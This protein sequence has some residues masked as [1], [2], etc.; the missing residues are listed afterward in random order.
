MPG[1]RQRESRVEHRL[2]RIARS[3]R[4][5]TPDFPLIR[6]LHAR[7]HPGRAA[8]D[9]ALTAMSEPAKGAARFLAYRRFWLLALG[10]LVADQISKSWIRATLPYGT[11]G[12]HGGIE[13]IP[14]FFYI[15]HV[16]N[17]GG[18]W[19]ILSGR[20]V[21]LA[22]VGLLVLLAVYIWRRELGVKLPLPQVCFGLFVGGSA[23][24]IVDRL[25]FGHVTDFFDFH[26][27]DYTYPTFNIADSA[28]C[29]GVITYVIWSMR[30]P[31]Q[32]VGR[33]AAAEPERSIQPGT[34]ASGRD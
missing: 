2:S 27:G 10:V 21:A 31:S 30:H 5:S 7:S 34:G 29:V 28:I 24:N 25:R 15:A 13:V 14:G 4:R 6:S 33:P 11:F 32:P 19:S 17:T 22:L 3:V 26:F 23:G 1:R 20:S 8:L 18:A 12:P 16:G 9:P